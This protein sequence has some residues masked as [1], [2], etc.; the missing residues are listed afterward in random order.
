MVR[1]LHGRAQRAAGDTPCTA[2]AKGPTNCGARGA[3]YSTPGNAG[4]LAPSRR[5]RV[6]D[7]V[8]MCG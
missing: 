6:A 1:P 8:A 5:S 4:L 2:R 7:S 3:G